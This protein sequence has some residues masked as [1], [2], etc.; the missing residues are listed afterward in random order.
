[1]QRDELEEYLDQ[2]LEPA[3][4]KDYCPNGLQ[5]EG[6][7]RVRRLVCGVTASQHVLDAAVARRADAILVHHG[8]FWRGEDGRV[9]GIRRR[10]LHTL[11]SHD[12]NLFAYHLPLD[13]HPEFGNNAELGRLMGWHGAPSFGEQD[14]GWLAR[15]DEPRTVAH[16]ARSVAARLG[17]E[18]LVLG[19]PERLVSQVGWCTGAAQGLLEQAVAAGAD[20]YVSGEVSE[21]TVHLARESGVGYLAAGH[22]AT[23][24]FGVMALGRHL[25]D[26][27]GLEV[28][29]VDEAN[30]V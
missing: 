10:R 23:E 28:A 29:F 19:D 6:K 22:H 16:I 4:L 25:Q 14:L 9:T 18:P 30:P 24:R 3:R 11:L 26:R 5:V 7:A 20:L 15:L 13:V 2:L 1:M 21:P 12:I 27:F 8:Y 17:R